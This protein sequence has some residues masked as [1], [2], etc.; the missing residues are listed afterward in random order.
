M[1]TDSN[2]MPIDGRPSGGSTNTGTVLLA[3]NRTVLAGTYPV[4]GVGYWTTHPSLWA[5]TLCHVV[6]AVAVSFAITILLFIFLLPLQARALINANCPEWAAWLVSVLFTLIESSVASVVFSLLYI[7]LFVMDRIFD[8]VMKQRGHGNIAKRAEELRKRERSFTRGFQRFL[9][10]LSFTL[11][12]ILVAPISIIPVVG[13][14]IFFLVNGYFTA[15]GCHLH[16]FD[17]L[18]MTGKEAHQY[19][20]AHWNEYMS[21]GWSAGGMGL[22]PFGIGTFTMFTS[23]VGSALWAADLEDEHRGPIAELE[24]VAAGIGP[25][26]AIAAT[27]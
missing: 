22:L 20:R 9:H 11:C 13:W 21:F 14:Y 8:L 27:V 26:P 3:A 6:I 15:W 10:P 2:T 24:A 17:Q 7:F 23:T 4:L 16:Y 5:L 19:M 25:A 18:Q 12:V 1:P